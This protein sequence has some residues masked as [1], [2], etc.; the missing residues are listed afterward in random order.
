MENNWYFVINPISGKGKGLTLWNQLQPL[1]DQASISYSFGISKYHTHTTQLIKTKYKEG[2]R[3]FIGL[4][5]DGTVNEIINGIFADY[6]ETPTALATLG[7][8]PIGTGND[9]VRNHQALTLDNII[10]RAYR[11]KKNHLMMWG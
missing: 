3:Q 7:L 6:T 5:G 4:G 1:L 11:F 9:W 8:F 2:V 10:A